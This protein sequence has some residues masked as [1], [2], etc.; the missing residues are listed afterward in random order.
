MSKR[1]DEQVK[2]TAG[3]L[4]SVAASSFT[5]GVVGPIV[6]VAI[7]LGD[8]ASKVPLATLGINAAFWAFAGLML[9][10]LAPRVL[11]EIGE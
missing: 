1:L 10:L 9:H 6:A 7:N 3:L 4:N 11:N 5:V 2:L 8:A